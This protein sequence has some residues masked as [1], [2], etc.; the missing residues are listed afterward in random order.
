[1]SRTHRDPCATIHTDVDIASLLED[2]LNGSDSTTVSSPEMQVPLPTIT[3]ADWTLHSISVHACH[4][5]AIPAVMQYHRHY[6][7]LHLYRDAD[8]QGVVDGVWA[9]RRH[10]DLRLEF[11]H[12]EAHNPHQQMYFRIVPMQA[13]EVLS[14]DQSCVAK[15][16]LSST[17]SDSSSGRSTLCPETPETDFEIEGVKE[18]QSEHH[19]DAYKFESSFPL[20]AKTHFHK[21]GS[22]FLC[23]RFQDKPETV[24]NGTRDPDNGTPTIVVEA[25]DDE[26][27]EFDLD[28]NNAV[29]FNLLDITLLFRSLKQSATPRHSRKSTDEED[30]IPWGVAFSET[31]MQI[32]EA[33]GYTY[34]RNDPAHFD[35]QALSDSEVRVILSE[36]L[37]SMECSHRAMEGWITLNRHFLEGK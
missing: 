26:F 23:D 25:Y 24:R 15:I 1:M 10:L 16:D 8:P 37:H 30:Q 34:T 11:V 12:H 2:S 3:L 5:S 19:H 28:E 13:G 35:R 32:L 6:M 7:I 18:E 21:E 29:Q 17:E 31:V 33:L 27:S 20:Q 36:L 14:Y 4:Q 22:S 9:V